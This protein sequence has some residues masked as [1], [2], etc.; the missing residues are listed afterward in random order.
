MTRP[1]RQNPDPSNFKV[2]TLVIMMILKLIITTTTMMMMMMVM[3]MIMMIMIMMM[4]H[5]GNSV[6]LLN[7]STSSLGGKQGYVIYLNGLCNGAS[8][9]DCF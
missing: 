7:V 9:F 4:G 8:A 6:L 1:N 3:M 2:N 5:F